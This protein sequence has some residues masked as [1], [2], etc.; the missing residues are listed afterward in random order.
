MLI[1]S[2]IPRPLLWALA[3]LLLVLAG[4]ATS[5]FSSKNHTITNV[6]ISPDGQRILL[7]VCSR[8]SSLCHL[9]MY[10]VASRR[11]EALRPPPDESWFLG[12]FSKEGT[13][14]IF[15]TTTPDSSGSQIATAGLN[16]SSLNVLTKTPGIK[17]P[18]YFSEAE[19][20]VLFSAGNTPGPEIGRAVVNADVFR[21]VRPGQVEK[22]TSLSAFGISN[23]Q[24]YFDGILFSADGLRT[25]RKSR[26]VDRT[27]YS[28]DPD[29]QTLDE[30]TELRNFSYLPRLTADGAI[31]FVS[32][33]P[34]SAETATFFFDI[35]RY[36]NGEVI[37]VTETRSNI[38]SFDIS[39]DGR[40]LVYASRPSE[41]ERSDRPQNFTVFHIS[42]GDV[43]RVSLDEITLN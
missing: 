11:S 42:S 10:D 14:I 43:Q 35:F 28:Y 26:F 3:V 9:V 25:D 7:T 21:I 8:R 29:T 38:D 39:A 36:D 4:Y 32:K 12:R 17:I 23:P 41:A 13:K 19:N 6:A 1:T 31:F 27:I 16:G 40:I 18:S 37:R 33:L 22:V 34:A 30:L 2:A 15:A 24:P 5:V 20:T